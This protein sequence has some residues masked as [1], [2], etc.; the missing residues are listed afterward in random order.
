MTDTEAE[1]DSDGGREHIEVLRE[2]VDRN[3]DRDWADY[4]ERFSF[5]I[6]DDGTVLLSPAAE[7]DETASA[8]ER[9][10][11]HTVTVDDG[12]AV[13]CNCHVAQR[14]FDRQSCRHMRAV[15]SH[16]RL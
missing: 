11:T 4:R 13:D 3:R 14:P 1:D 9:E 5:T 10:V 7:T 12:T 8:V 2:T 15:D 16:P 6:V